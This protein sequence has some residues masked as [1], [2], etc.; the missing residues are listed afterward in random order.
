MQVQVNT[1]NGL[2]NKESLDKWASEFL[3][4]S[5][6][7]FRQEITTIEV[8]LSDENGAKKNGAADIRCML[9]ARLTGHEPLAVSHHAA[10]Q[11]EAFRGAAHRLLHALDH[12][13]GKLDRHQHRDRDTIRKEPAPE[14]PV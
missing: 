7:R 8:Q 10:T 2:Q 12:K 6:S 3:N 1:G 14:S 11:D 9:E 5:L 13:Y 4:D